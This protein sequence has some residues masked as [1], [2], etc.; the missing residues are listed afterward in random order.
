MNELS[1]TEKE[2]ILGLLRMG[3]S[4]RRVARET[5]RRHETIRRYGQEAGVLEPRSAAAKPHTSAEVP[6][7]PKP[8]TPPEVPADL[9]AADARG[10]VVTGDAASKTTRSTC[11]PFRSFIAAELAAGRNAIGLF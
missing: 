6:A 3:W 4:V 11:E 5:G 10:S 1:V 2:T 7:D 9:E 8:P